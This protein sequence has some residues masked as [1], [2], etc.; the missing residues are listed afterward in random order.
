[1]KPIRIAGL[2][3]MLLS[4]VP[5]MA[6]P[7]IGAKSGII[8]L[9]EGK[10]YLGEKLLEIQ[11]AQFPEI[12]EN[13]VLRSEEGRAEVLLT[14]GVVLRIGENSSIKLISNRLVDTRIELLTGSAVVDA[15]DIAKETSVTF[16]HGDSTV[17]L[18]KSGIYRLDCEPARIKVFK[19]SAVV[20]TASGTVQ[21]G[22]GKMLALGGA[23][24]VAEK[25][26][27]NLTDSLDNWSR[28]RDEVM[29]MSNV[30]AAN[31]ARTG[32][33]G[34]NPCGNWRNHPSVMQLGSWGYNPYFGLVTYIPCRGRL[35]SPYGYQYWSPNAVYQA[36]YA[37]RP[38]F[39][40]S[41]GGMGRPSYPTSS[42]SMGGYSGSVSAAPSSVGASAPAAAR[43]GS[44]SAA[45]A[46]SSA[47]GAGA[48][49]GGGRGK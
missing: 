44:S 26:N 30:S 11:P 24:A 16:V 22:S 18:A 4:A 14:P 43:S 17:M 33:Y 46:G 40:P 45:S 25:F 27:T 29:A 39:T 15:M 36:F 3:L 47:V 34:S 35:S 37:P 31:R 42:P 20:K 32:G 19:G 41:D 7:V 21:V 1:M 6:Q 49:G 9:A 5:A 2:S 23:L 38:V 8:N 10:V 13:T 48:G 28:R 12:K